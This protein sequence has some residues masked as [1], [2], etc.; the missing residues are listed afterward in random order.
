MCSFHDS[1]LSER[2]ITISRSLPRRAAKCGTSIITGLNQKTYVFYLVYLI[3]FFFLYPKNLAPTGPNSKTLLA[4]ASPSIKGGGCG[5]LCG[6][7][8]LQVIRVGLGA[9]LGGTTTRTPECLQPRIAPPLASTRNDTKKLKV[10]S[11]VNTK[12]VRFFSKFVKIW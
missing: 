6:L 1:P 9:H 12:Y 2:N 7:T 5:V 10:E 4:S 8:Y 3:K 11:I